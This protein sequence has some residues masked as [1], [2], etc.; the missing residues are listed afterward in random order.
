MVILHI[1]I[2]LVSVAILIKSADYFVD[3]SAD[4][5][6]ALGISELV[7]GLTLVAVGTSLPEFAASVIASTQGHSAI[8]IGNVVGSNIANILL[9]IGVAALVAGIKTNRAM[10]DRDGLVMVF[11]SIIFYWLLVLAGF[12]I[13]ISSPLAIRIGGACLIVMFFAYM[14]FLAKAKKHYSQ[15]QGFPEFI[16]YLIDVRFIREM[17]VW[18]KKHEIEA[19]HK[20]H[21]RLRAEK[22]ARMKLLHHFILAV[23]SAIGIVIGAHFFIGE[24]IWVVDTLKILGGVVGMTLVAL[25]TSLPE[26]TVSIVA[27]KKGLGDMVIGNILGSNI[28]NILL[29][30]GTSLLIAPAILPKISLL[31]TIPFMVFTAVLLLVFIRTGWHIKRNEGIV[32][33]LLYVVFLVLISKGIIV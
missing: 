13:F 6:R 18:I 14:A 16:H 15:S 25:G 1:L 31:Y 5:A 33:M 17:G 23:A 11:A 22:K 24:A 9:V 30:G 3:A 29:V 10:L 7:I 4:V 19:H 28:A 32:F 27:A 2:L 20:R 12:S 26:L 21:S 8:A